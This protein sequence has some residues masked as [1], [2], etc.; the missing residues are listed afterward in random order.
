MAEHRT[1]GF[2]SVVA[3]L[4]GLLL[5]GAVLAALQQEEDILAKLVMANR[6]LAMEGLV[7]PYGHVSARADGKTFWAADHR[8]PDS[9]ERKHLKKVQIGLS[10]EAARGQHLYREIFIHSE[11]YRLL[12]AVGSVVHLHAPHSVALGTLSLPERLRPTT[13]PGANLGEFIPIYGVV[14]LVENRKTAEQVARA[15]QGQNGVLLRGHGAVVVGKSVEQAVLRAIYLEL[16]ARA[17]LMS[18]AAGSPIFFSPQE[19]A[20]FSRTTAVEHAWQYYAD[21][22]GRRQSHPR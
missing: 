17:Q 18:R 20:R 12:P 22:L 14:G 15:L 7:G 21:K 2:S 3:A 19:T 8:S 10:E 9:V 13:N 11:I 4:T 1:D 6:I 16:E 5:S